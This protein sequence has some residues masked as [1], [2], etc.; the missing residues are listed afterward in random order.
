MGFGASGGCLEVV[1]GIR[2]TRLARGR[3]MSHRETE[4]LRGLVAKERKDRLALVPPIV[5][6]LGPRWSLARSMS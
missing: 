2:W 1:P 3:E 4:H 6:C 5:A